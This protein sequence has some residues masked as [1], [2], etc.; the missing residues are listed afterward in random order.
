MRMVHYYGALALVVAPLLVVTAV[1][2]LLARG[3]ETHLAIGLVAA[4]TAVA[5]HTLLILFMIVTGRVLKAA[6][7]SRDL[8][9]AYLAQLNAFFARRSA[10]PGALLAA[11]AIVTTGV[12][13]YGQRGFGLPPAAHLA[14]GVAALVLNLWALTQGVSTLRRNQA[15]LD[16]TADE[17]DRL[18]ALG[19]APREDGAE[20]FRFG[21]AARWL[22]AAGAVWSP[23]LYW[24][25]VVWSGDL[26]RLSPVFGWGTGVASLFC[27]LCAGLV[28]RA[29]S[30]AGAAG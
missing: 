26:G 25:L 27:L 2:G 30:G 21:P 13:G 11:A 14:T 10:Y 17:L 4:V 24:G 19:R 18:D 9:G 3:G 7:R 15:L 28:R 12:L 16:R 1:S 29:E 5:A 20:A 6:M 22:I 8:D 23:W